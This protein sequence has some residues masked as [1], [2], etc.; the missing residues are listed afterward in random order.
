[1]RYA[2]SGIP[3]HFLNIMSREKET[4][5]IITPIKW[6]FAMICTL[7][8]KRYRCS[9]SALVRSIYLSCLLLEGHEVQIGDVHHV[10]AAHHRQHPVLHLACQRADV[11]ELTQLGLLGEG[12][13]NTTGMENERKPQTR[14]TK[15]CY[16]SRFQH[17]SVATECVLSTLKPFIWF[18]T[19]NGN[20]GTDTQSN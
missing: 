12:D 10:G 11:Q 9:G 15:N 13:E 2:C 14:G 5:C 1:M 8:E 18:M 19:H 16:V 20:P 4:K 6:R 7:S 17:L 3:P